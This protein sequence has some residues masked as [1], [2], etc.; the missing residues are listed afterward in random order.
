MKVMQKA[1]FIG[2]GAIAREHLFALQFIDGVEAEAVCDLSPARAESNAERFKVPRWFTSHAEMLEKTKPDLVHITTPPQSHF[3]LAKYCLEAGHNV[4]VE[5]PLTSSFQ[6]FG[7]LRRLAESQGVMLIENQNYRCHSS[8]KRLHDMHMAGAYGDLIEVQIEVHIAIHG[9]GSIYR[10]NNVPHFS[11]TMRGGVVGDFITHM[12]Y[13]AQM[14]IGNTAKTKTLWKNQAGDKAALADEFRAVLQSDKALA[15]LS[16]SGNAQ[17]NGFWLRV[18][19][20][21]GQGEANLFEPPRVS[22]RK[23]RGGAAPIATL[24]DGVAEGMAIAKTSV[25]GL[26]RKFSG[27]ARYDGLEDYLRN[28]YQSLGDRSLAY[29][30]I[31]D[32]EATQFLVE[33]MCSR[34]HDL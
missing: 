14:F 24:R 22:F 30:T 6:E 8:V 19:G 11:A 16:F 23:L 26:Y 9:E 2:T 15:Y 17:P 21:K 31:D 12:T 10:D 29:A 20:T 5:K 3:A 13:I 4:I 33:A 28:C 25:A 7:V 32:F 27:A 18:I 34:E 1:A